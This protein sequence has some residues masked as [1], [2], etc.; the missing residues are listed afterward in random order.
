MGTGPT[1]K[2]NNMEFPQKIKID[3]PYMTMQF[4]GWSQFQLRQQE[5]A[6]VLD[7]AEK[8]RDLADDCE[9]QGHRKQVSGLEMEMGQKME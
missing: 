8:F 6:T 7:E 5:E 4:Q 9:S 2:E 1:A 3:L